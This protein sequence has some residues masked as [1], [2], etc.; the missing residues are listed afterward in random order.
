FLQR[1]CPRI[2]GRRPVIDQLTFAGAHGVR[3][4]LLPHAVD[5]AARARDLQIHPRLTI[6]LAPR[7]LSQLARLPLGLALRAAR[8][9]AGRFR[10]AFAS[11]LAA[12]GGDTVPLGALIGLRLGRATLVAHLLDGLVVKQAVQLALK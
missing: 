9:G 8:L 4:F 1:L 2:L 12:L 5:V 11:L 6:F 10:G 7:P 3:I